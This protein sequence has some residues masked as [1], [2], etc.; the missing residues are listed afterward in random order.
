MIIA[1]LLAHPLWGLGCSLATLRSDQNPAWLLGPLVIW[2]GGTALIPASLQFTDRSVA[3]WLGESVPSLS[4]L[5]TLH[6]C[7][8]DRDHEGIT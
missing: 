8:S 3:E 2:E 1:S 4:K 5:Q 7:S 6:P